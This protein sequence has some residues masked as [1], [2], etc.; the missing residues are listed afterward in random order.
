MKMP[1]RPQQIE[2]GA[3]GW[4]ITFADM[5]C[6][7][8]CFFVLLTGFAELK[9]SKYR[10][11]LRS[12][13]EYFGHKTRNYP[14]PGKFDGVNYNKVS[15]ASAGEGV[16]A[17][18]FHPDIHTLGANITVA[19]IRRGKLITL[20]GQ[21]A[22]K[23]GSAD[24]APDAALVL[25]GLARIVSN[26]VRIVEVVGHSSPEEAQDLYELSWK[27]ARTAAAAL[28][29]GGLP[30]DQMKIIGAGPFDTSGLDLEDRPTDSG[31]VEIV[32]TEMLYNPA[33]LR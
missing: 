32:L 19:T 4:M 13:H 26:R 31:R 20:G 28:R 17:F 30:M 14:L 9:E 6:L 25:S 11:V 5:M 24:I 12:F 2:A 23:K 3:P 22:F 16:K 29:E 7:L 21:L 1:R 15:V 8:L 18:P 10:T 27:R 33:K